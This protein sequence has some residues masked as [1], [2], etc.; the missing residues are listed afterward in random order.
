[1]I[2][3]LKVNGLERPEA[4][5]PAFLTFSWEPE[6]ERQFTVEMAADPE[7]KRTVMYLDTRNSYCTYDGFPLQKGRTYY[8]RVRSGVREWARA[9]FG[10]K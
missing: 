9:Q 7:F 2:R 1:M 6:E 4:V 5:D 3:G 8:W 10:T